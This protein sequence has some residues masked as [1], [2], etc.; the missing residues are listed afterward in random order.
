MGIIPCG[1][2]WR[3]KVKEK[4]KVALEVGT[5]L[6]VIFFLLGLIPLLGLAPRNQAES[7]EEKAV[8]AV[9]LVVGTDNFSSPFMVGVKFEL[10]PEWYLYWV[11]P[12]DAGLP[13][14]IHWVLPDGL[15]GGPLIYPVPEKFVSGGIVAFGYKKEVVLL[16]KMTPRPGFRIDEKATIAAEVD[17]LVC[18]DSCLRGKSRPAISLVKLKGKEAELRRSRG[19]IEASERRIP[20]PAQGIGLFPLDVRVDHHGHRFEVE[21]S[22]SWKAAFRIVDFYPYPLEEG[23]FEHP[24]IRAGKRSIVIPIV[25]FEEGVIP[26][27]ITG[28]LI[29]EESVKGK[30]ERKGYKIEIPLKVFT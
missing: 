29:L 17:W 16:S 30:M 1:W 11:N 13:P 14:E 15:E 23:T 5:S 3:A 12:G 25:L 24:G 20:L 26:Q 28:V 6:R 19:L 8:V 4:D 2:S 27:V 22:F 7:D 18:K 21:A 9:E 10:A